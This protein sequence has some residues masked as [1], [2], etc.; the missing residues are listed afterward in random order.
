MIFIPAPRAEAAFC[1]AIS[2]AALRRR[3]RPARGLAAALRPLRQSAAPV[4]P[5]DR[6]IRAHQV[7]RPG[8]GKGIII[9]IAELD[10]V[11]ATS[12]GMSD[13]TLRPPPSSAASSATP[14]SSQLALQIAFEPS[15]G[16]GK[17]R[18]VMQRKVAQG[19]LG[20]R[21]FHPLFSRRFDP[22][23]SRHHY[24]TMTNSLYVTPFRLIRATF[25]INGKIGRMPDKTGASGF[26]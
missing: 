7:A 2:A 22:E 6:H 21:R 9:D 19:G 24:R 1:C 10:I 12:A 18:D 8:P 17:T 26:R 25:L 15:P 3:P 16:R 23:S 5:A 14:R 4:R 13:R 20:Q 11:G